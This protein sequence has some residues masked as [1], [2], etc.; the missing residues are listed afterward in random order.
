MSVLMQVQAYRVWALPAT[1]L[2]IRDS[3]V[4]NRYFGVDGEL[5]KTSMTPRPS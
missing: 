1:L 2:R 3:H 4:T 5:S